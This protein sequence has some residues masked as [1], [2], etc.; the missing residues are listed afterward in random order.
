[1]AEDFIDPAEPLLA[2]LERRM[3]DLRRE[4]EAATDRRGRSRARRRMRRL[5]RHITRLTIHRGDDPTKRW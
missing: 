1:M 4:Y 5:H 3:G 2:E